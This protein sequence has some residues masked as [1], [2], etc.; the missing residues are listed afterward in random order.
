[1]SMSRPGIAF[2]TGV[3]A[4]GTTKVRAVDNFTESKCNAC[5][6]PSEKLKYDTLDNFFEVLR[7]AAEKLRVLCNCC[8]RA[9]GCFAWRGRVSK[10]C[11][12]QMLTQ[13]SDA[14]Q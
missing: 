8:D 6:E 1:M 13:R 4:D 2:V 10:R 11:S 5:T 3:R 14:S 7:V 12:K 9:G